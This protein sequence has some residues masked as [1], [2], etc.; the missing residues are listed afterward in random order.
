MRAAA[1]LA[2]TICLGLPAVCRAAPAEYS[3]DG[4]HLGPVAIYAPDGVP[5][6]VVLF[7]SGD[8]GWN[9]G[10]VG[11]ARQLRG[12]GALV[13]GIDVRHCIRNAVSSGPGC[14]RP[15][16]EFEQLSHSLQKHAGLKDYRAPILVGYSSGAGV[17]YDLVREG[18]RGTFA[19]AIS[20]GFCA[21]DSVGGQRALQPGAAVNVPW[22]VLHG[23]LDQVCNVDATQAFVAGIRGAKFVVL[24][25]VGHGYSVEDNW[26]PQFRDAYLKLVTATTEPAPSKSEVSDLP[27]VEISARGNPAGAVANTFAV[28][29][30]GDGGYAGLDQ[31]VAAAL[32]E[33]GVPVIAWSTL[34]YFWRERTP[35]EAARDLDRIVRHYTEAW[36][37]QSVLLVGYS[38]GAN[39]LPFLVNRLPPDTRKLVLS[40]S[41]VAA[42]THAE[43]EIHVADW[44]PGSVPE[45][46]PVQPALRSLTGIPIL[47]LSGA[48][49]AD[50]LCAT[51]PTGL[52]R[53]VELPGGHHFDGD[54]ATLAREILGFSGL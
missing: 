6:G 52:A 25:K 15:A 19:G 49:E 51:L 1:V 10:V 27:L 30:T 31:D 4:G 26:L 50:N 5:G 13:A 28:L 53:S 17:V 36:Q 44:I 2:I 46:P 29:L 9:S 14:S 16:E 32:A 48:G 39:A 18:A 22:V 38:F 21:S 3:V 54:S 20:L 42:A 34:R 40:V 7:V 12:L 8:G 23:A 11:M 33:R 24:P 37:R 41:L 43:F 35:A 45:G 47:C